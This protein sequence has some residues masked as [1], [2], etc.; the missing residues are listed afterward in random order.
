[1]GV[2]ATNFV[3]F[4]S[5]LF[6]GLKISENYQKMFRKIFHGG[7][8]SKKPARPAIRELDTE[9]PRPA[10]VKACEWPSDPFMTQAGIEEEFYM[11]VENAQ[12]MAS[13]QISARSIMISLA[14]LCGNFNT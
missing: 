1:V 3:K 11:Y 4:C 13:C 6:W 7:S 5:L 12:L 9:S 8:S 14:P 2:V 10:I